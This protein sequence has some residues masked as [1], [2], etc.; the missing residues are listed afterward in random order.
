MAKIVPAGPEK[1][2]SSAATAPALGSSVAPGAV[3]EA[4][5][6]AVAV[7]RASG[8]SSSPA[9]AASRLEAATALMPMRPRRRSASRRLIKPS[10]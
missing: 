4:V 1:V 2:M 7:A 8:S 5:A 9:H 3:A 6:V 10:A